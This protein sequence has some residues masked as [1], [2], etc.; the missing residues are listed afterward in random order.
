MYTGARERAG[1]LARGT[2][3][4]GAPAGARPVGRHDQAAPGAVGRDAEEP[5]RGGAAH[6]DLRLC[7]CKLVGVTEITT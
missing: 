1:A 3:G 7:P 5:G 4:G 2:R 6:A